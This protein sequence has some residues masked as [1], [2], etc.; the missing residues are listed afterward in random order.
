MFSH[1]ST[2]CHHIAT[3]ALIR[4]HSPA[5]SSYTGNQRAWNASLLPVWY[6][7]LELGFRGHW[8]PAS[9]SRRLRDWTEPGIIYSVAWGKETLW[10]TVQHALLCPVSDAV[11][12]SNTTLSHS[13]SVIGD[14]DSRGVREANG[15]KETSCIHP[16]CSAAS[17]REIWINAMT[18]W[19]LKCIFLCLNPYMHVNNGE[20]VRVMSNIQLNDW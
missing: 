14:L 7:G 5:D 2:V 10:H 16:W 11:D 1:V 6:R 17:P 12:C 4:H 18:Y 3:R 9:I 19:R 20:C 13:P 8:Q 15:P